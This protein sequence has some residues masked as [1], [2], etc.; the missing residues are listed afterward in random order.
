MQNDDFSAPHESTAARYALSS[1]DNANLSYPL[2]PFLGQLQDQG[3]SPKAI[4]RYRRDI[5]FENW[6]LM[7][8]RQMGH[9]F[10]GQIGYVGSEGT[11]CTAIAPPT[12]WIRSRRSARCRSWASST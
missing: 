10:I 1:A 6:N 5:Y 12:C 8:Q 4:D 2:T 3:A 11:S 9:S 7:L